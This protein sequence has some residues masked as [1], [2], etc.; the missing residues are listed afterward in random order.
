MRVTA[1]VKEQTQAAI[2]T[3]ARRLFLKHGL[4]ATS[5]RDI[6]KAAKIAT[7]TL[8]NYFATKHDLAYAIAADAFDSG[9][10]TA[11]RR[12]ES[13]SSPPKAATPPASLEM[14]L[15]TLIASDLRALSD[16]RPLIADMLEGE[17]GRMTGGED[18]VASSVRAA[19]L[20]DAAWS[21]E[22]H[23][24]FEQATAPL[25]HLYWSLYLGVL[26]FWSRD[27]SP[28]QE[29]SL[30][31]LDQAIKMFTGVIAPTQGDRT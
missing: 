20:E 25:L 13:A 16:L 31:L 12:I 19:R 6:A 10:E 2:L 3:A 23:G 7:G 5:T 9:R 1:K 4:E 8:F 28:N 15:F 17:L 24:L 27:E 26:A 22:R 29:D 30:A 21:L 14:D 11:R 18:S